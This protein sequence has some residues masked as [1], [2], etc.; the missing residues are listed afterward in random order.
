MKRS[1]SPKQNR[2]RLDA[3]YRVTE[4]ERRRK[5]REEIDRICWEILGAKKKEKNK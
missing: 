4:A 1:H 2:R 5:D 3:I